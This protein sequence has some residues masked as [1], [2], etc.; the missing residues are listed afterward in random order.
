M[1]LKRFVLMLAV[2]VFVVVSVCGCSFETGSGGNSSPMQSSHSEKEDSTN[3]GSSTGEQTP[4]QQS[5]SMGDESSSGTVGG[6]DETQPED[7]IPVSFGVT[8]DGGV[9]RWDNVAAAVYEVTVNGKKITTVLTEYKPEGLTVGVYDVKVTAYLTLDPVL[10]VTAFAELAVKSLPPV[11]SASGMVLTWTSVDG[12]SY[13][14]IYK[15]GAYIAQ[16]STNFYTAEAGIYTVVAVFEDQRLNSDHS[17]SVVVGE[18]DVN[19]PTLSRD[20]KYLKWTAVAGAAF[21][22]IYVNGELFQ[23]VFGTAYDFS[24]S[25]EKHFKE[26]YPDGVVVTVVACFSEDLNSGHSNELFFGQE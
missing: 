9:I 26:D 23:I 25:Y 20:G 12:A 6:E 1:A 10:S 22:R 8:V 13:Y 5:S 16:N 7:E 18:V 19:A 3:S 15:E 4:P 24:A 14:E 17:N 21:Y 2:C 11:L